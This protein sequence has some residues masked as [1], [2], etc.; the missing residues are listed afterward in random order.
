LLGYHS[1]SLVQQ[2]LDSINRYLC[3]V[4]QL[5]NI[6]ISCPRWFWKLCL[7]WRRCWGFSVDGIV[8]GFV[9]CDSDCSIGINDDHVLIRSKSENNNEGVNVKLVI[10]SS[11]SFFKFIAQSNKSINLRFLVSLSPCGDHQDSSNNVSIDG[12]IEVMSWGINT[13]FV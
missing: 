12:E 1:Y 5:R 9:T 2:R 10:M 13:S 11:T 7:R 3:L 6:F 4:C 8:E